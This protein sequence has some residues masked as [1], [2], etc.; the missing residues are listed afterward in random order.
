MKILNFWGL[1][2]WLT[3]IVS[4]VAAR[5]S[6]TKLGALILTL[7]CLLTGVM[8]CSSPADETGW[9]AIENKIYNKFNEIQFSAGL[10]SD[11]PDATARRWE[12][13]AVFRHLR[14]KGVLGG[15][16]RRWRDLEGSALGRVPAVE[17][18]IAYAQHRTAQPYLGEV[19]QQL[20]VTGLRTF[21]LE[22]VALLQSDAP[23]TLSD[24]N[25]Y[26]SMLEGLDMILRG[27]WDSGTDLPDHFEAPVQLDTRAGVALQDAIKLVLSAAGLLIDAYSGADYV[28][29]SG[30]RQT[31]A[32]SLLILNETLAA[33]S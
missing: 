10:D 30:A 24:A 32:E 11:L 19:P 4:G 29:V 15:A 25:R 12:H 14:G 27:Y 2:N 9:I 5:H 16:S 20:V 33:L 13:G 22:L 23:L 31:L 1:R 7:G 6:R 26:Y 21:V 28:T 17:E 18:Q 8:G 3:R